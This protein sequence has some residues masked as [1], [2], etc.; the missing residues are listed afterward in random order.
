MDAWIVGVAPGM[1]QVVDLPLLSC[2]N[3]HHH[4][5]GSNITPQNIL[6]KNILSG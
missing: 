1:D 3:R 2:R 5:S 4:P 6:D